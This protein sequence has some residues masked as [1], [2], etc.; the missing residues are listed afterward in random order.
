VTGVHPAGAIDPEVYVVRLDDEADRPLASVVGYTMHPTTLGPGNRLLSPDWPGYLKRTMATLTAA[1]C[2][3]AQG[4][5]GDIGPGPDGFTAD[6]GVIRRL[7][8]RVACAAADVFLGLRTRPASFRHD[9][10]Q[11]S[12]APL[13]LWVADPLPEEPMV[14]R[15]AS[16]WVELPV[17][18]QPAPAEAAAALAA[19]QQRLA[20]LREARAPATDVEAATFVV[21]RA[22]MT[23]TRA[24]TFGGGPTFA[25]ELHA[26]RIGPAVLVGSECEPFAATGQAIKRGS[27]F[28]HTW[29]G[30]Y[31][32]GWFGYVPTPDEIPRGGYEVDT[33]PYAAA[34][35]ATLEAGALAL[36]NDLAAE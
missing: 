29:F 6:L 9:R 21:K 30:G 16:R 13:G 24:A 31:T 26:L 32:G 4:A 25:V 3:F 33:S 35:A 22:N 12:G 14:V 11:E 17:Q 27:P 7:G 20:A 23:L 2:L 36:L 28:P 1:P 34:A 10:V 18:P 5:T 15:A 8:A 19:A